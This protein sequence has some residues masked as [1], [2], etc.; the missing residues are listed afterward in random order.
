MSK[1]TMNDVLERQS[2]IERLE[3]NIQELHQ[4]FLDMAELVN[5]QGQTI[6]NIEFN[7]N[8]TRDYIQETRKELPKAVDLK[9]AARRVISFQLLL[10]L[11][12]SS[13]KV[14][15]INSPELLILLLITLNYFADQ[16]CICIQL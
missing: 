5:E 8:Q 6:D 14:Q 11:L 4:M 13:T 10:L 9:R 7:V 3:K 15:L 16:L 12:L 1:Q 2:D